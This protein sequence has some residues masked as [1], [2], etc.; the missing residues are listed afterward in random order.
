[1]SAPSRENMRELV[2]F[3]QDQRAHLAAE[4]EENAIGHIVMLRCNE[5]GSLTFYGLY[6]DS[7]EAMRAATRAERAINRGLQP[8]QIPTEGW[9]CFVYPLQPQGDW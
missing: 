5:F 6:D 2:D 3:L 9:Q 7:V 8:E 1:M 4:E